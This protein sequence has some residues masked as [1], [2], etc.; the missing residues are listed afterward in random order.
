MQDTLNVEQASDTKKLQ[1]SVTNT[2]ET[3]PC[4]FLQI[5]ATIEP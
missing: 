4:E 1:T 2:L 3:N 5:R